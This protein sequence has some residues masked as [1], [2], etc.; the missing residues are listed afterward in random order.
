MIN[1]IEYIIAIPSYKRSESIGLNTLKVLNEKKVPA[2]KIFIFVA[3][4]NE[5]MDYLD[6]VDKNLYNKII[7]GKLGLKI[8]EIL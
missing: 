8:K 2:S 7:I 6:N 1:P 3:N 4:E 5:E